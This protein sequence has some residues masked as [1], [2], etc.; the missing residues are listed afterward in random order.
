MTASGA[1]IGHQ[2][3]NRAF[4]HPENN[5]ISLPEKSQFESAEG[6]YDT[7]LHELGHWTGYESRLNR[8]LKHSFG[9]QGY[10]K[11]EL[12]AEIASMMLAGEIGI[13]HDS[14]QNAAYVGAWIKVLKDDPQEIYRA[15]KDAEQIQRYVLGLEQKQ[16]L[17]QEQE[18]QEPQTQTTTEAQIQPQ[19]AAE[20]A[21]RQYLA[22][23]FE[24]KDEAKAAGARWDKAAK[25][26]YA[27]PQADMEKLAKFKADNIAIQQELPIRPQ[28]EFAAARRSIGLVVDGEHPIMDGK[29]H[30]VAVEGGKKGAKDGFYVA[31]L[32][33]RPAGSISNNRTGA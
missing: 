19:P 17:A 2:P 9:S 31:H 8:D 33:G 21:K 7:A 14:E 24:R 30:R 28:E 12:R 23:P 13:A 1:N 20:P 10:A 3:G 32:D 29:S 22:E 16:Q 11:E 4:Y 15:A 5:R 27:G 6:Y 18:Q 26:W 25:A